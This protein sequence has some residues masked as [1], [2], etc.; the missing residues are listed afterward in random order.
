MRVLEV[1]EDYL[2]RPDTDYAILIN[3][4]WGSGKTYYWKHTLEKRIQEETEVEGQA[5]RQAAYI[6]L[7]GVDNLEELQ[8]RLMLALHGFSGEGSHV[9]AVFGKALWGAI[10]NRVFGDTKATDVN[11][12]S[13]LG[14]DKDKHVLCFDDL[15]RC[16]LG[17]TETLGFIN[18]FVE[19]RH[20]KTVIIANETE[21]EKREPSYPELKEKLVGKTVRFEPSSD[22]V[23]S[24]VQSIVDDQTADD[25]Y[26]SFLLQNAS[27]IVETL[28]RSEYNNLRSLKQALSDFRRVHAVLS[29][30]ASP[31]VTKLIV[32][33]LIYTLAV[34][35]EARDHG[36]TRQD[37]EQFDDHLCVAGRVVR[38]LSPKTAAETPEETR[39][40]QFC[41]KYFFDSSG[42][43]ESSK[44]IVQYI[45]DG[46][47]D[48]DSLRRE[49]KQ[50]TEPKESELQ[51]LQRDWGHLTDEDFLQ[52]TRT[53]IDQARSGQL[54]LV[55][56]PEA[57]AL[58]LQFAQRGAIPIPVPELL[59]AFM[60]GLDKAFEATSDYNEMLRHRFEPL[61]I[62]GRE[63]PEEYAAVR[64]KALQL[65]GNVQQKSNKALAAELLKLAE[66]EPGKFILS[67]RDHTTNDNVCIF[68]YLDV[69]KFLK[70]LFRWE[71]QD[72]S[73]LVSIIDFRYSPRNIS[74]VY[75]GDLE[76]IQR[77][78]EGI[79]AHL[80]STGVNSL[81]TLLLDSVRE[82]LVEAA[83]KLAKLDT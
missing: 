9:A 60:T 55:L 56:Y 33:L 52:L 45:A 21:L 42:Q 14:L 63:V 66:E 61:Q 20:I 32:D 31:A 54:P 18:A 16:K 35:F 74:E 22:Y 23:L 79:T 81:H 71:N 62:P 77:L 8:C 7:N 5:A 12:A 70:S 15:E 50:R 39:I 75:K 57:F 43:F 59:D 40:E 34:T 24:V 80:A 30:H 82:S 64:M 73:D 37:L 13:F 67:L 10:S 49:V 44:S 68:E 46:Y 72:T 11:L 26:R 25:S 47:L 29:E 69:D 53:V 58:L 83:E 17:V 19:H 51:R 2:G 65:Y 1:V 48:V 27:I 36:L 3:G 4:D 38:N 6:S 28:R 78:S 76:N 41:S